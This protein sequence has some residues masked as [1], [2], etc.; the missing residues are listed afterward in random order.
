ML[1]HEKLQQNEVMHFWPEHHRSAVVCL[2]AHRIRGWTVLLT[3]T[4]GSASLDHL[5][6][7]VSASDLNCV[8]S[9][10]TRIHSE[11]EIQKNLE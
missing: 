6:K 1:S 3:Q 5:V 2:S 10:V 4:A 9:L 8:F 7:V 11:R